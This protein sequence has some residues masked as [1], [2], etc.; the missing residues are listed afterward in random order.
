MCPAL[1]ETVVSAAFAQPDNDGTFSGAYGEYLRGL[2]ARRPAIIFAFPPKAAGTFLRSAAIEAV[3]GQLVRIVHAQGCRDAQPYLPIFL[4]YYAGGLCE[5]PLVTHVHMQALPGNRR[6][7]EAFDLKPIIMLRPIPDM[8]ASYWDMLE[9]D[10]IARKDGLNCVIPSAFL[11]FSRER[12][13]DYL[14]DIIGP[15]YAGYFATWLDYAREQPERICVL[16]YGDFLREPA[17]G[18]AQALDHA[19]LMR[20][21]ETCKRA[22]ES[23]WGEREQHRFNRGVEGRGAEYFSWRHIEH[24]TRMLDHYG[25][26]D[27][28]FRYLLKTA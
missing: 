19:G 25:I 9:N 28:E 21:L 26:P 13:A 3:G 24:L 1:D 11:E 12:K 14:I 10:H 5:G 2:G 4:S 23:T 27:R 15:W 18:L 7:L 8:L 16:N 22:V 20:T 17:R 6:F